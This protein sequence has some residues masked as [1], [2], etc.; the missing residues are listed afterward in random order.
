MVMT[1]W[2]IV[3]AVLVSV[4]ALSGASEAAAQNTGSNTGSLGNPAGMAPNTPGVY[5]ARPDTKQPNTADQL[6][7]H[8]AVIGGQAEV[9]AGKLA[10]R[11][12]QSQA[13]KDFANQMVSAHSSAGERLTG[14]LKG[15]TYPAS[16]QLDTD[17]R[18]MM[19]E[20]GKVNGK[21][22]DERYI[23][24]QIVDHQKSAQL[25]EWIIDNGQD[26]R[27]QTYAMDTL[28]AVL[29]H[30]EMAKGILAQLTGSAP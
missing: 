20:L 29:K 22:F 28:P 16:A 17:H 18:V 23:R 15:G 10:A 19:D 14:L 3:V 30:L 4:A 9:Q 24:G 26:G 6:F 8:E 13:V 25:Y 2:N 1:R 21:A 5:D 11:K 12:A 27:L 7:A